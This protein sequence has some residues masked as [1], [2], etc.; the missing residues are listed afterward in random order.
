MDVGG[1]ALSFSRVAVALRVTESIIFGEFR[2]QVN[3]GDGKYCKKLVE[4]WQ[5]PRSKLRATQC[6]YSGQSEGHFDNGLQDL[7]RMY[8]LIINKRSS[9]LV[10]RIRFGAL[11]TRRNWFQCH[12]EIKEVKYQYEV[13][14][15][16]TCSDRG[17]I[18]AAWIMSS[19]LDS[20]SSL[21]SSLC[22]AS[23]SAPVATLLVP[24]A[25]AGLDDRLSLFC[26]PSLWLR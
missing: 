15:V 12:H 19:N 9:K 22:S 2:T 23:A 17:C 24:A 25:S 4:K 16:P 21:I 13:G 7:E 26:L 8:I 10:K 6:Q 5:N 3:E 18:W 14:G 1:L 20:N 11:Q